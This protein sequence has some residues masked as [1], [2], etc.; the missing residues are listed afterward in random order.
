MRRTGPAPPPVF[1][2]PDDKEQIRAHA[3]LLVL[4]D[5]YRM[6][7]RSAYRQTHAGPT[8]DDLTGLYTHTPTDSCTS[9][10]LIKSLMPRRAAS[11]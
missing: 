7:M 11:T 3:D 6:A 9:I 4:Q 10:W 2:W 8:R 1:K 5:R